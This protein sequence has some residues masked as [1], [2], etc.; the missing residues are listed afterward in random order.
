MRVLLFYCNEISKT[1]ESNKNEE[2]VMSENNSIKCLAAFQL[3]L[4]HLHCTTTEIQHFLILKIFSRSSFDTA[5]VF[6]Y[7]HCFL[8]AVAKVHNCSMI[9]LR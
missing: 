9:Y 6:F 5:V 8:M 7:I 4:T 3:S 1:T 2:E